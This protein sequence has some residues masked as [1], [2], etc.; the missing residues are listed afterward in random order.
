M[1]KTEWKEWREEHKGNYCD[2]IN[3]ANDNGAD[4]AVSEIV[5]TYDLDEL[6]KERAESSGWCAVLNM[7]SDLQ[8]DMNSDYYQF[9]GYGNLESVSDWD[10]IADEVEGCLEFD[11]YVCDVCGGDTE[12]LY[13]VGEW[14]ENEADGLTDEMKEYLNKELDDGFDRCLKC[15]KDFKILGKAYFCYSKEWDEQY[16]NDPTRENDKSPWEE[17]AEADYDIQASTVEK[18]CTPEE[19]EEWKHLTDAE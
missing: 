9:D 1:T 6:V 5:S 16:G 19:F 17:F 11:E 14:L 15:W 8:N 10:D 18:Y 13:S 2:L 3:Y 7:L 4:Q 12:E